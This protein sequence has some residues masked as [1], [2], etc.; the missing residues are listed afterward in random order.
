MRV[1][2]T[3][4]GIAGLSVAWA[5]RQRQPDA[6]VIV[7]ERASRTGG[8]IRTEQVDGYLCESGPQGFLDDAPATLE[9]VRELGLES[10]L[11]P[12]SDA[13]RHR[14]IFRNGR[15]HEVPTSLATLVTSRL[16][17]MKGK[18]RLACEPFAR[19]R[20]ADEESIHDFAARRIGGEA[21][22]VLVDAMV[23]GIFG[24][25]ARTLSLQGCF[26]RLAELESTHGGL[27]RAQIAGARARRRT[28]TIGAPAGRLTSFAGGMSDLTNALTAELGQSVRLSTAVV[29]VHSGDSPHRFAVMT[30]NGRVDADAVVMAGPASESARALLGIDPELADL[31]GGIPTAPMAVLCLGYDA[32]GLQA[33]CGLKGFGFL[34]PRNEAVRML[35]TLWENQIFPGRAPHGKA[36]LRV[37][38]GGACDPGVVAL[39]DERV[40]AIGRKELR[41]TMGLT[42]AP[43]FV[44]IIRHPRGIPQYVTGHVARMENIDTRLRRYPGLYL[45]G[46]S[47]RGVSVNSCVAEAGRIAD[48]VLEDYGRAA[49]EASESSAALFV[50]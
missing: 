4:A 27:I 50:A 28:Q 32:A 38:M 33:C 9:L 23:S 26:P 3:G 31:V 49:P 34:V 46:N 35:G 20:P 45:A 19:R 1:V 40:L 43:E 6:D 44:R 11:Q 2:V 39:D 25:N 7:L 13:A 47:Y 5:L 29:H 10:R 24:G 8:N 37:M 14:Y 42:I 41:I 16:L 22:E 12:C 30:S 36:L 21:A 17:S 15:L 18:A 48:T